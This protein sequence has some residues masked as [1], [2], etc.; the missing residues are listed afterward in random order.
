MPNKAK[1]GQDGIFGEGRAGEESGP[2]RDERYETNPISSGAGW[3][4]A[5]EAWD[6][7]AKQTQSRPPAGQV[8]R[9]GSK[10]GGAPALVRVYLGRSSP[11]DRQ[12]RCGSKSGGTRKGGT[13]GLRSSDKGD[14][15]WHV[16][17]GGLDFWPRK[18]VVA[19]LPRR[20]AD[21]SGQPGNTKAESR[22]FGLIGGRGTSADPVCQTQAL[23]FVKDVDAERFV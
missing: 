2:G 6:D 5:A 22:R 15:I 20:D 10:P 9:P 19:C 13:P 17:R 3:D 12:A 4:E 23:C 8:G 21:P 7:Y 18:W 11:T 16:A 1:L 14:V